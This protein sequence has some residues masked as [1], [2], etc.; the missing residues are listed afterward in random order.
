MKLLKSLFLFVLAAGLV[1]C[2]GKVQE[3]QPLSDGLADGATGNIVA[4]ESSDV[5][6]IVQAKPEIMIIPSDQTLKNAGCLKTRKMD[7]ESYL[8]RNYQKF[9]LDNTDFKAIVSEIQNR[10]NDAAFPL[11]D[12]EQ[13][14]KSTE[15]QHAEDIVDNL[16]QDAKTLLLQTAA[17]DIIL[18]LSYEA[19]ADYSKGNKPDKT[20]T[21]LISCIDAY[22]NKVI[23][24]ISS[25]GLIGKN[26]SEIMSGDLAKNLP[27]LMGN[28]QKYFSDILNRGREI[29]VRINVDANSN[30]NLADM[31]I[32]GDTYADAIND[33]IKVNTIKGAYKMQTNTANQLTF[34]N[35]RIKVLNDDGTQYGVYDWTRDLQRHLRKNLGL[36]SD[37]RS[38]GL[39]EVVLTIKG[40]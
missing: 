21:Y 38:Q 1:A 27:V 4:Y 25:E 23:T 19:K 13:T 30:Q 37:N 16:A 9:L 2:G 15:N 35:V 10:F 40:M 29:T 12:L 17:P 8:I 5:N 24:T 34:T 28:I 6:A 18:E 33:Y 26:V 7:G 22:T 11:N 31:N 39:G 32:E 36:N 3:Q 14:L 20:V